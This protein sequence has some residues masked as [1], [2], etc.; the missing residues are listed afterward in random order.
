MTTKQRVAAYML[1]KDLSQQKFA[2]LAGLS[3]NAVSRIL[4]GIKPG[5]GVAIKLAAFF[6]LKP[7]TLMK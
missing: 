2:D 3:Q 4:R 5:P 7:E 1:T 6:K